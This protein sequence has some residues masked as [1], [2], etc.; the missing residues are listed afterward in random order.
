MDTAGMLKTEINQ[1][2]D[3]LPE[4]QLRQVLDFVEQLLNSKR[5][6]QPPHTTS[7]LPLEDDP[8]LKFI[9]GASHGSLAQNIDDELYE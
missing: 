8:I 9:G 2:L 4:D 3:K 6:E 7:P 5:K 1:E